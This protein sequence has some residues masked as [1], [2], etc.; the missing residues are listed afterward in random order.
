MA[1]KTLKMKVKYPKRIANK[2]FGFHIFTAA[3]LGY[4]A[5]MV[6]TGRSALSIIMWF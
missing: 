2:M 1:E 5:K 6:L 4:G 3:Y